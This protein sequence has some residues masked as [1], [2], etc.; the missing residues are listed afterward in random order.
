MHSIPENLPENTTPILLFFGFGGNTTQEIID[1]LESNV[2]K[3]KGVISHSK[4]GN[5]SEDDPYAA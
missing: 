4:I 2:V 5:L 3:V 1:F